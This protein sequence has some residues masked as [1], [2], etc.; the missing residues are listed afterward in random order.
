MEEECFALVVWTGGDDGGRGRASG[1]TGVPAN[2]HIG[3]DDAMSASGAGGHSESVAGGGS[4]SGRL[5]GRN[6]ED[7]RPP[8]DARR[9]T[10]L[11]VLYTPGTP[12][13]HG[14]KNGL[15]SAQRRSANSQ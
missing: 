5:G 2:G 4:R 15:G 10:I 7:N 3:S 9:V 12:A 14:L 11:G 13:T 6:A 8:A 1:A